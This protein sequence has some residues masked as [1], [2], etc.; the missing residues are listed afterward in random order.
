L[1]EADRITGV[2]VTRAERA[3]V[4]LKPDHII[5]Y[6]R[7]ATQSAGKFKRWWLQLPRP[8]TVSGKQATMT[9]ASGQKLFVTTLL[10]ANAV[11]TA[12]ITIQP[13][14][15]AATDDGGVLLIGH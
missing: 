13:G 3:V 2:A 11:L 7:A 4:W 15:G 6:D 10:R 5:V 9:T 14:A 8:A 1:V 12:V